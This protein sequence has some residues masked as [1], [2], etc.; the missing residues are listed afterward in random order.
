VKIGDVNLDYDPS[1]AA[2]RSHKRLDFVVPD[3]RLEPGY[4]YHIPFTASDLVNI[5]GYQFTI[6]LDTRHARLIRVSPGS[7]L[8]MDAGHFSRQDMA[9]GKITTSW[10]RTDFKEDLNVAP[11]AEI[12]SLMIEGRTEVFLSDIITINSSLTKAEAYDKDSEILEV[13]LQFSE[14]MV[15][16]DQFALL[17][18]RPN[19]FRGE[20]V[21]GFYLPEEGAATLTIY[22][23]LGKVLKQIDGFYPRGYHEVLIKRKELRTRGTLYYQLDSDKYSATKKM[24]LVH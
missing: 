3:I 5:E 10:N 2:D 12:F 19:P 17:Q 14:D 22:D 24:I 11:T 18:N 15:M 4:T 6:A 20:T 8:A 21:I 9:I 23:A 16:K 13:G 7:E 1:R